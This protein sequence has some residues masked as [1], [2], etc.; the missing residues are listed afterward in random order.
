MIAALGWSQWAA[1]IA[2]LVA[3]AGLAA[4]FGVVFFFAFLAGAGLPAWWLGYLTMLARPAATSKGNAALEWYPPGRLVTWAAVLAALMVTFAIPVMGGDVDSFRASLHSSLMQVLRPE[5]DAGSPIHNLDRLVDFL[6]V[7][8]PPAA[9][10]VAT[11]SSLI[12]L[13]LAARVV[14][15]SGLLKRPWPYLPGM[16]F[17]RPM[18]AVLTAAVVLSFAGGLVGLIANVLTAS[19][20]LAYGVLGLAVLHAITRS[21]ASR[22]FLLAGIYAALF[23]FGWPLLVLCLLGLLDTAFDLRARVAARRGPP[24][25]T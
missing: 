8:V 13:W 9:A 20:L 21:I 24:A 18:A 11:I 2:A 10:I 1:L 7:V 3:A 6:V 25:P 17:P 15:F 22:A 5:V 14:K 19:L 4:V 23:V 16:T 12:N